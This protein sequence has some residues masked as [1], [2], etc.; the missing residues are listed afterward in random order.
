MNYTSIKLF[1]K[2]VYNT[3]GVLTFLHLCVSS[4]DTL[5][6][7]LRRYTTLSCDYRVS[8]PSW[9]SELITIPLTS[10][11]AKPS[12]TDSPLV[13]KYHF[14]KWLREAAGSFYLISVIVKELSG[15]TL[16]FP[17]HIEV[18]SPNRFFFK[19]RFCS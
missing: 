14:K 15:L 4:A 19:R 8:I 11:V 5:P 9:L 10:L 18:G 13:R 17:P 2:G 7:A 12:H 16:V 3:K 6:S 1:R